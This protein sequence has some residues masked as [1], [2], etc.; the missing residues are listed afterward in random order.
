[1]VALGWGPCPFHPSGKAPVP[2][3]RA[4]GIRCSPRAPGDLDLGK[5]IFS[6]PIPTANKEHQ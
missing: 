1:M 5:V 3:Q 6:K 4:V 2:L